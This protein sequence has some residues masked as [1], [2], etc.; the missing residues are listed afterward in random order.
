MDHASRSPSAG[1]LAYAL[2]ARR[3]S[4]LVRA[5]AATLVI[6]PAVVVSTLLSP[7][8]ERRLLHDE[9]VFYF[10]AGVLLTGVV[11]SLVAAL[12]PNR[13]RWLAVLLLLMNGLALLHLLIVDLI[14]FHMET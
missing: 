13:K 8:A 3:H 12:V 7:W 6:D 11:L 5:A 14:R 9:R 1:P 10:W 2:P 4:R